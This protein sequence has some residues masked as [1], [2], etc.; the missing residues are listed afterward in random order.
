MKK[1]A[2]PLAASALV[3]VVAAAGAAFALSDFGDD[4]G[5]SVSRD[6]NDR[7]ESDGDDSSADCAESPCDDTGGG[8]TAICLEG[9]IDCDDTIENPGDPGVC[10][11]IFPTPP[12]CASPD[13]PV[14]NAPPIVDD[15][16][17]NVCIL[18]G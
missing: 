12:E 4:D 5:P 10:I 13:D 17:T 2:T 11:Q 16:A 3:D 9:A 7:D 15:P 1:W 18:A 8:P 6:A 14:S